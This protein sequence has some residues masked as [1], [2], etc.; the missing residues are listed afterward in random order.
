MLANKAIKRRKLIV[1]PLGIVEYQRLKKADL[2]NV[3][4]E[5]RLEE[6]PE[7]AAAAIAAAPAPAPALGLALAPGLALPALPVL[8][9]AAAA[10]RPALPALALDLELTLQTLSSERRDVFISLMPIDTL[11]QRSVRNRA[12]RLNTCIS[13]EEKNMAEQ[14]Q[15][16]D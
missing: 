15:R 3:E 5:H 9:P 8:A 6:S 7:G 14:A 1:K 10:P 4:Q 2:K 12:L 13:L 16:E 11:E